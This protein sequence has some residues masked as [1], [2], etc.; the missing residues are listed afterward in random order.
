MK[1]LHSLDERFDTT[2]RTTAGVLLGPL[3]V[4]FKVALESDVQA[5]EVSILNLKL[6]SLGQEAL[7]LLI[8]LED[9]LREEVS[10]LLLVVVS[11][12]LKVLTDDQIGVDDSLFG[13]GEKFVVRFSLLFNLVA[14]CKRL[15]TV[16]LVLFD[17]VRPSF[18]TS[19]ISR[20]KLRDFLSEID[21]F[22]TLFLEHLFAICTVSVRAKICLPLNFSLHQHLL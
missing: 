16:E 17:Q 21:K 15:L 20:F 2:L 5:L 10:R 8:Q 6:I 13:D 22:S 7:P 12:L 18:L 3:T 14:V 9:L 11:L 19:L 4:L 1:I